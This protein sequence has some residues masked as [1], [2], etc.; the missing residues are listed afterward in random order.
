[1][2]VTAFTARWDGTCSECDGDIDEGDRM[3]LSE[4]REPVCIDCWEA[5][6]APGVRKLHDAEGI[7]NDL[8]ECSRCKPGHDGKKK[9]DKCKDGWILTAPEGTVSIWEVTCGCGCHTRYNVNFRDA[10]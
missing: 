8:P 6:Y 7:M 10:A 3:G 5:Y 9:C 4:D 1:M 2:S